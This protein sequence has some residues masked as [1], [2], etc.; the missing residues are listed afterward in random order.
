M[1]KGRPVAH[2]CQ[3]GGARHASGLSSARRAACRHGSA[4]SVG[5]S[6]VRADVGG[7]QTVNL[8]D[9]SC[10]TVHVHAQ[11]APSSSA[12]IRPLCKVLCA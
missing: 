9:D 3:P 11:P 6:V 12:A 8:I 2:L 1:A 4:S 5:A 10:G 7:R